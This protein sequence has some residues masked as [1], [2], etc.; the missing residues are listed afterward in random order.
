MVQQTQF[1]IIALHFPFHSGTYL[2]MVPFP[3][4]E[5][6]CPRQMPKN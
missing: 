5:V 6:A 1:S 3:A 4:E 2:V